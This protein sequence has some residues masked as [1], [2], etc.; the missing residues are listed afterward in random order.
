MLEQEGSAQASRSVSL[1]SLL[2][3]HVCWRCTSCGGHRLQ[4]LAVGIRG[5][6]VFACKL[7]FTSP[8][9]SRVRPHACER[10]EGSTTKHHQGGHCQQEEFTIFYDLLKPLAWKEEKVTVADLDS[11]LRLSDYSEVEISNQ[12]CRNFLKDGS[13]KGILGDNMVP[14]IA[15]LFDKVALLHREQ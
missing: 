6:R 4:R 9:F 3:L 7:P 13:C 11:L 14:N 5:L 10:H 2:F 8:G 1:L 12:A 15:L